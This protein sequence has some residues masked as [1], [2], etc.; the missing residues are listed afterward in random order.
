MTDVIKPN[1]EDLRR[2]L[3]VKLRHLGDVLLATPVFPAIQKA[4]PNAEI[5]AC[6][7]Q[8]TEQM[9]RHNP[10][11]KSCLTVPKARG[12][13]QMRQQVRLLTQL[14]R[15]QFDLVIDLTGSDRAAILTRLTGARH[16][17]GPARK[18]GF[19]GKKLCYTRTVPFP[20]NLHVV[21]QQN[22]FLNA[23]EM[24]VANPELF[25]FVSQ[26]NRV[27]VQKLVRSERNLVHVHPVS[28]IMK[29]CWPVPFMA[30]FLNSLGRR[31]L[32]PVITASP[33]PVEIGFIRELISLLEVP[34]FDLSGKLSLG[35][36]G[37]LSEASR[38]FVGVDSAPMHIAAAVGTPVI[39]IFGPSSET[40]WAPWCE[41]KLVLSRDLPCRLPCNNKS[42]C[43]HIECLRAMTP[44]MV[45]PQ[46]DRFLS[47][48]L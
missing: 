45:M 12:F 27:A 36:L 8:G 28:R 30:A 24:G 20:R 25:F 41:K 32:T 10:H 1:V 16:R 38:L 33:D 4:L 7:F 35:E 47:T 2:I 39:G 48:I 14:R 34:H 31:G 46:V 40:L 42:S 3:V 18:K 37:A 15:A 23:F 17:W 19:R 44:E 43:P 13:E 5:S 29:K 9:L 22:S 11:L 6:V 21:E 26:E